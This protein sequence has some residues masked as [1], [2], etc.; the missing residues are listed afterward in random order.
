MD[1]WPFSLCGVD[2]NLE[3]L[4]NVRFEGN[5]GFGLLRQ[6]WWISRSSNI[7]WYTTL[8]PEYSITKIQVPLVPFR[9][10]TPPMYRDTQSV[11]RPVPQARESWNISRGVSTFPWSW[12]VLNVLIRVHHLLH[13]L[14]WLGVRFRRPPR[15]RCLQ[16]APLS[17]MRTLVSCIEDRNCG[18]KVLSSE[19]NSELAITIDLVTSDVCL[20]SDVS[21]IWRCRRQVTHTIHSYN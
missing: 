6:R 17:P 14:R 10:S 2:W 12:R 13:N 8:H 5:Q 18:N 15:R 16:N 3:L 9:T 1:V 4:F 19:V 21:N 11:G 7:R 20:A